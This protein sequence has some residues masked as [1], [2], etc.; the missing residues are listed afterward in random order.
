MEEKCETCKFWSI[1]FRKYT[2]PGKGG[3]CD[4]L[5]DTDEDW[6]K[7]R[8]Y[9]LKQVVERIDRYDSSNWDQP[10]TLYYDWCGEWQ[11][12]PT[13]QETPPASQETQS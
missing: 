13:S 3:G 1:M 9:P 6:G 4:P 10:V 12:K 7:C 2:S 8:R 5:D 11:P